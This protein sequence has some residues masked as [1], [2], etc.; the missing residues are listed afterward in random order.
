MNESACAWS[1]SGVCALLDSVPKVGSDDARPR[2]HEALAPEHA[3]AQQCAVAHARAAA[4]I[5]QPAHTA[6]VT[7]H[8]RRAKGTRS[9]Y[10]FEP[11]RNDSSWSERRHGCIQ[12]GFLCFTYQLP[13][14][15]TRVE[16]SCQSRCQDMKA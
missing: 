2:R 10:A 11:R 12:K 1:L 7:K 13:A 15:T 14:T 3:L 16:E 9:P 6:S 8:G 5:V 4:Q